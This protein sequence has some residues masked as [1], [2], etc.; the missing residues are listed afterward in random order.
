MTR[1][2]KIMKPTVLFIEDDNDQVILYKTKFELEGFNFFSASNGTDGLALARE[3]QPGLIFLDIILGDESGLD[4]LKNL[5]K[6]KDT[7]DIPTA[8]FTNLSTKSSREEGR[9]LGAIAYFVKTD[10]SLKEL[11][12]WTRATMKA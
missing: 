11:V 2:A 6:E 5:K 10:I 4:V 12:Q 3:K 1:V 9:K 7:K 8:L